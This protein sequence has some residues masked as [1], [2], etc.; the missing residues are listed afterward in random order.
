MDVYTQFSLG[1]L[2]LEIKLTDILLVLVVPFQVHVAMV[3]PAGR[4]Q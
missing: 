1:A 2:T 4:P 3:F